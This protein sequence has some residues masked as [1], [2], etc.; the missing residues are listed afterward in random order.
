MYINDTYATVCS[1]EVDIPE[2]KW[3]MFTDAQVFYLNTIHFKR[4]DQKMA[5]SRMCV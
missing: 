2:K 1:L 5:F 4:V 3:D